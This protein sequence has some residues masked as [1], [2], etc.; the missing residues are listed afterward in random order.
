[1]NTTKNVRIW[2]WLHENSVLKAVYN[3]KDNTLTVYN[4]QDQILLRRTG[5]TA[6]II[7]KIEVSFSAIGAKRVDGHKEPFTYL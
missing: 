2:M 3:Q 6:E 5:I 7:V 1:M 4:E